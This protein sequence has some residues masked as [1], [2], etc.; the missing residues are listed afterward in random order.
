MQVA[1]VQLALY[2]SYSRKFSAQISLSVHAEKGGAQVNTSKS[3]EL[4][5]LSA[6]LRVSSRAFLLARFLAQLAARALS[7]SLLPASSR[8]QFAARALGPK[9]EK[10]ST[11]VEK[12]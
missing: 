6:K 5:H 10:A 1:P 7:R 3:L 8:A 4:L 9:P 12:R 11:C 2:A